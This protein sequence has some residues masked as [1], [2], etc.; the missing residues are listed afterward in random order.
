M[1]VRRHYRHFNAAT[2]VDAADAYIA[3]LEGGGQMLV[4]L[5][6][7]MS[8]GEL[9]VSLAE[10]IRRG[11]VHAISCTGANLEED[12]FNLVAHDHYRR[13]PEWRTLSPEQEKELERSGLNRVTDTCIPEE[14]AFRAIEHHVFRLWKEADERGERLFP[15]EFM[16]R[17]VRHELSAADFQIDPG[18]L[19]AA[20]GRGA[21]STHLR[22]GLGRLHAR[23]HLRLALHHR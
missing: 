13:I 1:L 16:Y 22:P 18:G 17:L 5:A 9:G 10:M 23:Q 7:A 6:G 19:L 4:T 15:H 8:T 20:G 21:R 2:L 11:K 14:A 3:H 12:V